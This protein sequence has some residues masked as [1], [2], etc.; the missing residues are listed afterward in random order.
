MSGNVDLR[1]WRDPIEGHI[2]ALEVVGNT[3][4]GCAGPLGEVD[5]AALDT[6]ALERD[7]GLLR[8]MRGRYSR[9]A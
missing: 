8:G 5:I 3:I 2:W 7:S 1:L 6:V 4:T 9:Y